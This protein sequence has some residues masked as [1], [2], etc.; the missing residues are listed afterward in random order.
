MNRYW[1]TSAI[2]F[3]ALLALC[4]GAAAIK[5]VMAYYHADDTVLLHFNGH[6]FLAKDVF[7]DQLHWLPLVWA[8]LTLTLLVG[9]F[10]G[11]SV[12]LWIAGSFTLVML[13]V[14]VVVLGGYF[15]WKH[16]QKIRGLFS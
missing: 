14:F 4:A 9:T 13:P 15:F 12:L 16:Q 3:F 2:S 11:A 1:K 10:I 7:R 8:G 6:S 5:I